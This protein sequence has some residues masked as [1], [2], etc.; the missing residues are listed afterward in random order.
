[1][2]I[3]DIILENANVIT[4]EPSLPA[5]SVVASRGG[6]ILAVGGRETRRTFAG[7]GTKF[8]DC[9]GKTVIPG[10]IDAHCHL[11]SFIRK[12]L[13]LDVGPDAVHCIADIKAGVKKRTQ[14]TPEGVWISGT[15]LSDFYLTEKRLPTRLELDEVAPRNPVVLAHAG[16][17][18]A[19]LNSRALNLAG[20]G[21]GKPVPEGATVEKDASGEPTGRV[22]E[23]LG[24]IREQ[25]MPS[26]TDDEFNE[27]MAL[28]SRHY[29]SQG[30]TSI[31]EATV[32]NNLARFNILRDFEDR[33]ILVPRVYMMFGYDYLNDFKA[34][35]LSFRDGDDRLRLGG[36]KLIVTESTGQVYPAQ[37]DLNRIVVGSEQAGF[38]V[39]VHAIQAPAVLAA[40]A[41][42]GQRARPELRHRLE[43][44]LECSPEILAKLQILKPVVV[45][46]PPF[47]YYGG[48][49]MLAA[50]PE[51]HRPWFYNFKSLYESLILAG[52][53]DS[54][55]S[56][57]YPL[58]GIY[59]AM[60][61][62]TQGGQVINPLEAI[63]A[64]EG[65]KMYTLNAAYASF[66][67]N[68]KGSLTPGKLTDMVVLSESPL[69]ASPEE[70]KEIKVMMTIVGGRVVWEA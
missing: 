11:F 45:T 44:C 31:G 5:A 55:V 6:R 51:S 36:V 60:S 29:L 42:L 18:Q 27:G 65:L 49:R 32:V 48:D 1:M 37:A 24:Y 13:S 67:E 21:K 28:V 19:V 15:G 69:T 59:A 40:V 23:L 22:Y 10:F 62:K 39:A 43:H 25:V 16:L 47:L 7:S 38:P 12:L 20:I 52:S 35:G 9:Q 26:L 41:A 61:R 17:H 68:N 70:L 8:I 34:A 54:P 58:M 3:A 66:D 50:Q 30:I 56:G 46:Q 57:D 33:G 4:M 14:D 63:S 53:S 2:S 64:A